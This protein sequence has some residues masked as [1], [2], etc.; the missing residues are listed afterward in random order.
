M[1]RGAALLVLV[2]A[3]W[4]CSGQT[5]APRIHSDPAAR[6][7]AEIPRNWSVLESPD[8]G[9]AGVSFL[10]P[11]E[12]A[13]PAFRPT[14]SAD[15]YGSANTHYA[16]LQDYVEGQARG[17]VAAANFGGLA[18]KEFVTR[19]PL[20]QSREHAPPGTLLVRTVLVQAPEG[21]YALVYAAPEAE[22]SR[23]AA[24]FERF[25]RSFTPLF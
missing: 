14:I 6:F 7:S 22:A 4:G 10:A 19:R 12:G 21:F 24:V 18:G 23:H 3:A 20:P 16:R 1:N 25:L 17:P 15:Y 11:P 9:V 13:V 5:S 2:I 8:S